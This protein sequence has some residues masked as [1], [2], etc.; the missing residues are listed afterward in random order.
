MPGSPDI[1]CIGI[2]NLSMHLRDLSLSGLSASP[3]L[4]W[5][6]VEQQQ[7]QSASAPTSPPSWPHLETLYLKLEPLDSYG[8]FY[9]AQNTPV[10]S[11]KRALQRPM[12]GLHQL[13]AAAGRAVS[14]GGMPRLQMMLLEIEDPRLQ[15]MLNLDGDERGDFRLEWLSQPPVEWTDEVLDAWGLDWRMCEVEEERW[16]MEEGK[17]AEAYWSFA[18]NL[19]PWR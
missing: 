10:E 1:L 5:P 13:I 6:T 2:R 19:V 18:A 16:V 12:R 11:T 15:V 7:P 3:E 17:V 14:Q 9:A 8:R 4:F